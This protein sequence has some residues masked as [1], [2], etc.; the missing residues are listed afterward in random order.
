MANRFKISV[1]LPIS[2]KQLY[3]AWLD[4]SQHSD[5][6][7]YPA[8]I[9]PHVGGAFQTFD[10]YITGKTLELEPGRRIIQ[11]WRTKEF[12]ADAPDSLLEVTIAKFEKGSRLTLLH[13]NLPKDQV[14]QYKDRWKEYYFIPM[15]EFYSAKR[16][17]DR[18]LII[19]ERTR[20]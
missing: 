2:P 14:E 7:G 9:I 3:A 11:S 20:G 17:E 15:K 12:P 13:T 19:P 4:S 18:I 10:D 6:T 1:T 16:S 5:F 8:K